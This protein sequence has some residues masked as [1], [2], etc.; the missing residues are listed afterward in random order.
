[1]PKFILIANET[2]G[3]MSHCEHL[4]GG[5]PYSQ[6]SCQAEAFALGGNVVNFRAESCYI[7]RCK[8]VD[9]PMLVESPTGGWNV[10]GIKGKSHFLPHHLYQ[11]PMRHLSDG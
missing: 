1:M 11:Y 3:N 6:Q 4:G 9:E 8:S 7:K 2:E 10:I 5:K